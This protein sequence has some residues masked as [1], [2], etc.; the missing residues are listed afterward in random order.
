MCFAGLFVHANFSPRA[1]SESVGP[2]MNRPAYSNLPIYI[3]TGRYRG[4]FI[5][6]LFI[7]PA[8]YKSHLYTHILVKCSTDYNAP[9]PAKQPELGSP[10]RLQEPPSTGLTPV[11]RPSFASAGG[12]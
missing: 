11:L 1:Q 12:S 7:I 8:T 5:L 2:V 10:V 6:D 9:S 3:E 4:V